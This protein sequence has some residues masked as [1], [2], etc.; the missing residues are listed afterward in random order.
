MLDFVA[1]SLFEFGND[2]IFVLKIFMLLTII[3]FVWQ[4]LGKGP[5]AIVVI[6]GLAYLM[7]MSPF[8]WFFESTYILMTLLMFG[9]GGVLIDFVFAFPGIGAGMESQVGSGKDLAERSGKFAE[10]RER[11][12]PPKTRLP[13]PI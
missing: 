3:S 8:A 4:H 11:M 5:I 12:H 7:L 10:G 1:F 2:M 9:I 13:P 6:A